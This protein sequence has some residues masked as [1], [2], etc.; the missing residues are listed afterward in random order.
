MT[1]I[2]TRLCYS[3][4]VIGILL[5]SECIFLIQTMTCTL[6]SFT[7]KALELLQMLLPKVKP[8]SEDIWYEVIVLKSKKIMHSFIHFQH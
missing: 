6:F 5:L 8:S 1:K 3:E 4:S 7:E 2:G